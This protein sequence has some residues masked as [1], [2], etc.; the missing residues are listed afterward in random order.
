MLPIARRPSSHDSQPGWAADKEAPALARLSAAHADCKNRQEN[1]REKWDKQQRP[2]MELQMKTMEETIG[3][4][5][6]ELKLASSSFNK[7]EAEERS[8]GRSAVGTPAELELMLGVLEDKFIRTTQELEMARRLTYFPAVQGYQLRF[9]YKDTFLGF[10][11]LLLEQ[12]SS[13]LSLSIT[14]GVGAAGQATRVPTAV[15][16]ISGSHG[17]ASTKANASP[18]GSAA[19]AGAPEAGA[20]LRFLGEGVSL[21]TRREMLGVALAPNIS[22]QRMDI[23]ARFVAT[24]PLQYLPRRKQWRLESGFKIEVCATRQF[25]CSD[26]SAPRDC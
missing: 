19:G 7:A 20:L 6:R 12:L 8:G 10:K 4:L 9:S 17:D 21:V 18:A 2:A 1:M 23:T 14:P 16:R 13:S 15:L 11:E 22:L 26:S 3:I 5:E 25:D 24:I